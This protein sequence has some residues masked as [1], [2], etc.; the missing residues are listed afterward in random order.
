MQQ[1][2]IQHEAS[3]TQ[4]SSTMS[5]ADA[6]QQAK[7]TADRLQ[8]DIDQ[9]KKYRAQLLHQEGHPDNEIVDIRNED[10]IIMH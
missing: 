9:S 3:M 7:A 4:N 10:H 2:N 1:H 8:R 6:L 5:L